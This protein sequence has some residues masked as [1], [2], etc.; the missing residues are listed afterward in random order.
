[1]LGQIPTDGEPDEVLRDECVLEAYL[2][3]RSRAATGRGGSL[4]ATRRG[5]LDMRSMTSYFHTS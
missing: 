5:S 2:G 3:S 1:V 4:S